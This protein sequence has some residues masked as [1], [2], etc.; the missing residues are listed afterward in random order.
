M[1]TSET[2]GR[3]EPW[4]WLATMAVAVFGTALIVGSGGGSDGGTID[5]GGDQDDTVTILSAYDF[6]IG[7]PLA[8]DT[9]PSFIDI[10]V[11]GLFSLNTQPDIRGSLACDPVTED[12][13]LAGVA[14]GTSVLVNDLT[15]PSVIPDFVV[16]V[17][18][19]WVYDPAGSDFPVSGRVRVAPIGADIEDVI[20]EV[21]DCG[22]AGA[23]VLLSTDP[24][25]EEVCYPWD[26]FEELLDNVEIVYEALASVGWGAI[27]F[28][29]EQ[30]GYTLDVLP[31][32]DETVFATGDTVTED[33]DAYAANWPGGPPNPGVTTLTWIDDSGDGELGPGDSFRQEF[34][35]CW[36]NEADDNIDD[37]LD[38]IIEYVSYTEVVDQGVTIRLGFEGTTNGRI[39]G[40][41]YGDELGNDP[42]VLTETIEQDGTITTDAPTTLSGR[43]VIVFFAP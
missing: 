34:D 27:N 43:Y 30:A 26:V 18:A 7:G 3:N 20:V 37:L 8:D 2:S 25:T 6:Q 33:C 32:L 4:R 41:G 21:A 17:E 38:G 16:T 40:V 10:S 28:T 12:C 29:L 15:D 9:G 13:E 39:G 14:T 42:L 35:S 5:D 22:A 1:K 24:A 11:P 36:L 19:D 31:L 23:G